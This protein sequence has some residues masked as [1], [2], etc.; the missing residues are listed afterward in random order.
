MMTRILDVL[1]VEVGLVLSSFA[2]VEVALSQSSWLTFFLEKLRCGGCVWIGSSKSWM[3]LSKDI[4]HCSNTTHH[5]EL[6]ISI[7][8][9]T[10]RQMIVVSW[11]QFLVQAWSYGQRLVDHRGTVQF[12]HSRWQIQNECCFWNLAI[13]FLDLRMETTRVGPSKTIL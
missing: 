9:Y 12:I 10:D 3:W 2:L 7:S 1:S 8:H 4:H 11:C 5:L 13:H 6:Y